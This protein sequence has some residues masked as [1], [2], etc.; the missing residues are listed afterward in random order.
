MKTHTKN[1]LKTWSGVLA[2]AAMLAANPVYGVEDENN[3]SAKESEKSK[4]VEN[5][6]V[7][8]KSQIVVKTFE[9]ADGVEGLSRKHR[10]WLGVAFEEA[11]EVLISQLGLDPGVGLVV[12]YVTPE[13]PAAK[14]G[15]QKNDVLVEFGD[16]WLVHPAQ[17]QKLVAARKEGDLI[18]LGYFR[19]GK[20]QT[21]S[22]ALAKAAP[23]FGPLGDDNAWTGGLRDLQRQLRE[24]PV[25]DTIREQMKT[26][27]ETLGNAHIDK[28][29]QEDI[30]RSMEQARQA[31]RQALKNAGNTGST[32]EPVRKALEDL[33]KAIAKLGNNSTATMIHDGNSVD[34]LVKTDG[35]GTIIILRAPKLHLTAHDK[36]GKLLFDGEIETPEQRDKVPRDLWGKVEP[37]LKKM[38]PKVEKEPESTTSKE[39]L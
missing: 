20:K 24:A 27:R 37:M 4:K 14:A 21:V 33:G 25:G 31:Y 10:A 17:M 29:V 26:L 30:R 12:T 15:L 19:A 11:P 38:T 34:S 6:K 32:F 16:Q 5:K 3:E 35:S 23:S 28:K 9:P 18:K 2:L 39:V 36:A 1:N 13:S 7:E 8:K 22:I